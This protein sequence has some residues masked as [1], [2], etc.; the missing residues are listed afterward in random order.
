MKVVALFDADGKVHALF[1]PSK[2]KD[3]PQFHFRPGAG[4]RVETLEVPVELRH[5]GPAAL[6]RA[7]KV[8]LGGGA[9]RLVAQV[10]P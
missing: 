10:K 1:H 7:V 5:L 6:H 3:A 9:P 8:E 4:H 2:E